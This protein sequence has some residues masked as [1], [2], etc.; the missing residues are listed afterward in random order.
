MP[1]R[2]NL[3][4]MPG[5]FAAYDASSKPTLEAIAPNTQSVAV[6]GVWTI[7]AT[8]TFPDPNPSDYRLKLHTPDGQVLDEGA[9]KNLTATTFTA[10][11]HD[12]PPA[13]ST[14]GEGYAELR[15]ESRQLPH[16]EYGRAPFTW[17]P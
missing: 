17:T 7:D 10:E 12:P 1:N 2:A 6:A 11:Y 14:P 8:G 5:L 4:A 13:G 16:A 9:I 15:L 3:G